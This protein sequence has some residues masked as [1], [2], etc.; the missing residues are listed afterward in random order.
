MDNTILIEGYGAIDGRV[1]DINSY[2]AN[3]CENIATFAIFTLIRKVCGFS[4]RTID[5]VYDNQSAITA[6]WRYKNT[7]VFDKTKPDTDVSKVAR[8]YIANIRRYS[9]VKSFWEHG[10]SD[11]RGP[12]FATERFKYYNR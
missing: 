7:S 12:P 6:T 4:P 3:I 1:K 8:S 10:H 11:K 2:I 5:H 9:I